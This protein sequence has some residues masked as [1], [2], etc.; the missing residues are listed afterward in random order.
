M[1]D[2]SHSLNIDKINARIAYSFNIESLRFFGNRFA[3][4]L[5]IIRM[6]EYRL[7]PQLRQGC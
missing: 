6:D 4:I 3:K 7:N 5:R 1:S 2:L